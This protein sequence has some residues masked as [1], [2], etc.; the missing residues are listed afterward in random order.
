SQSGEEVSK[1][2]ND[3]GIRLQNARV[4]EQRLVEVLRAKTGKVRDILEVEREIARVRGEIEQMESDR[5]TLKTRVDYATLQLT[6][7]EDF[8]ASLQV[9][10]PSTATRLHNAVVQGYHDVVESLIGFAVWLLAAGPTL[11]L[12]AA[13]LFF[14]ARWAWKRWKQ[15]KAAKISTAGAV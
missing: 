12:W 9:A 11:L 14:P 15:A 1:Q 10:P 2:Y 4:T 5:R 8:R 3:L 13:V 7:N 6:V